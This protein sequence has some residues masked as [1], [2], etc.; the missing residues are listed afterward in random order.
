MSLGRVLVVDDDPEVVALLQDVLA[1]LD[2]ESASAADGDEALRV[3]TSYR[4]DV[5]LL[6]LWLPGML[7]TEVLVAL[8]RDHPE[9][10][11]V[12]VTA[13]T[14]EQIGRESL[15][16]GAFDYVRKPF[17]VETLE[18][19]LT[20]AL[21]FRA[22]PPPAAA[23]TTAARRASPSVRDGIILYIEDNPTN[24]QLVEM[25]LWQRPRVE[26]ITAATGAEGLR[27]ARERRP[28]L[29][30]LD[31]HLPDMEGDEVLRELQRDPVAQQIPVVIVSAEGDPGLPDRMRA[32]GAHGY[33]D[34]PLDFPEFFA[35]VD[36]A[37]PRAMD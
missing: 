15:A 27:L 34:K 30:L 9:I 10:P 23:A 18:R 29:I 16:Q 28:S 8:R 14:D 36:A 7:G 22:A 19:I 6:D 37:L 11:V 12:M 33:L 20:A 5:I 24:V 35:M 4:P 2:Y 31:I 25:L 3:V 32:A 17:D 1:S 13:N 21:V 26:F